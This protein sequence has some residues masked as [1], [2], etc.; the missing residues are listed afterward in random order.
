MLCEDDTAV[1]KSLSKI[2]ILEENLRWL[3]SVHLYSENSPVDFLA[4]LVSLTSYL[5]ETGYLACTP[6][7]MKL[8][9]KHVKRT[10]SEMN[11]LMNT[12]HSKIQSWAAVVSKEPLT[13]SKDNIPIGALRENRAAL[14]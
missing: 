10:D 12:S 14:V 8:T 9:H 6:C 13:K 2:V 11:E 1:G 4:T 5:Q 7:D 3:T